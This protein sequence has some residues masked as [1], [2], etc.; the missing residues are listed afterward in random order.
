M[1]IAIGIAISIFDEERDRVCNLKF[2]DRAHA[3]AMLDPKGR[4]FVLIEVLYCASR[5]FETIF[6][7][8]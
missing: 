5:H 2:G 1:A 8:M 4:T 3:L 7:Q 6:I